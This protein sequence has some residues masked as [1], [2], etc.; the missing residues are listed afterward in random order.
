MKCL[1]KIGNGR[2]DFEHCNFEC[3]DLINLSILRETHEIVKGDNFDKSVF[4]KSVESCQNEM[5]A[6]L[7][8]TSN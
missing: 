3:K 7:G 5:C 2:Y 6:K 4:E 8:K 1:Y